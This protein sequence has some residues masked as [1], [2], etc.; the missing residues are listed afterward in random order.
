MIRKAI[1]HALRNALPPISKTEKEA[2]ESGTV[3][4]EGQIFGGNPDWKK[5]FELQKPVL[6]A[7]EQAFLDGPVEQLCRM[8]DNEQIRKDGDMSKDVWDFIRQQKFFALEIPK[9]YG[10]LGFSTQAHAAIVMKIASVSSPVAMTVIVPNSLG[11]AMIIREYGTQEQK[12]HYLPRLADGTEIP[13][14]ALTTPDAGSDATSIQD[15]GTVFKDTDGELKIRLN[16]EKRYI[17]LGPVATI[18]GLAFKLEDPDNLLGKGKDVGITVALVPTDTPGLDIGKRH[19]PM[20]VPFQNGPNTGRDVVLPVSSIVGGQDHAGKGWQLL[21]ECLGVGRSVSLPASSTAAAQTASY[22]AG[23]YSR[24]RRQF[25]TPV[26]KF[27]GVEEVLGR[28]AGTTYLMD[29]ARLMTLQMVDQGGR[30][31]IPS[32]IIKYH[33]TEGM[34]RVINDAMDVMGGK[35]VMQGPNNLLPWAYQSIPVGI[36]VEGANI[37]TR[38]LIIFG[39]GS[40]RSHPYLLKILN[41]VNNPDHKQ[42]F[43]DLIKPTLAFGGSLVKSIAKGFVHGVTGG[44]FSRAPKNVD[45]KTKKYYRQINRLSANLYTLASVE[46]VTV[47]GNLKRKE[48]NSARLGDVFSHLY[49]ASA[50]LWHFEQNGRRPEDRALLDWACTHALDKAETAMRDEFRNAPNAAVRIMRPLVMPRGKRLTGT[51]DKMDARAADVIRNPGAGLDNLTYHVFKPAE[52]DLPISKLMRAF[53]AAVETEA[54]E[55]KLALAIRD[56]KVEDSITRAGKLESAEKSGALSGAEIIALRTADQLRA[57]VIRVD[58][59][60]Q[61]SPSWASGKSPAKKTAKGKAASA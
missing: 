6:S 17:T 9:E 5:L 46:A 31:A 24:I 48:R 43:R 53:N 23:T 54:L 49:M 35:A 36:T 13:A 55:K 14:F 33:A 2:L 39:Q 60:E 1:I 18:M 50:A 10:G 19:R 32:A 57:E 7:E 30:P 27:E 52:S 59:F 38:N 41:A 15:K 45:K 3:G 42:G 16:W 25:N 28:M 8:I 58:H 34:R 44:R 4:W 26:G 37:M 29:A 61:D 22:A 51:T 21:V 56:G 40:M 12:D 20:D 47:G 11:P